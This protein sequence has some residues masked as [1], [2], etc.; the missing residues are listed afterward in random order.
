VGLPARPHQDAPGKIGCLQER[1]VIG[2]TAGPG[3]V[4]GFDQEGKVPLAGRAYAVVGLVDGKDEADVDV[5]P[6]RVQQI[7]VDPRD[8]FRQRVAPEIT[9]DQPD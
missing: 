6:D 3:G 5:L 1:V 8:E 7:L 9:P 2:L 4:E